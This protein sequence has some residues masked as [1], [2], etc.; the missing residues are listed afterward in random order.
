MPSLFV[1]LIVLVA[2][3]YPSYSHPPHHYNVLRSK[4]LR[5]TEP[6]RININKEKVFVASSIYDKQ[7]ELASGAW[8]QNLL[9]LV[10]L[11]GP[12]NV[13]LSVFEDDPDN[14]ARASLEQFSKQLKCNSSI[15][16]GHVDRAALPHVELPTGEKR[17]KR[18]EFLAHVRNRALAPLED[19]KSAAYSVHFDKLLYVNDVVFDPI[20]AANLIFSTNIDENG[21]AKYDA[22]CA[23]DFINPFKYYDTFATRDDQGNRIGVPI[24]PWF[25]G[26]D[27]S[28]SRRDVLDQKDAVR[29]RSCWG[30]MTVFNSA[31][32][33]TIPIRFRANSD[34][35]WDASECCLIHAD[36]EAAV[37]R[38]GSA[39]A[40]I[41]LNPYIRVAYSS[42]T[43]SYLHISRRFERLFAPLQKLLNTSLGL[44]AMNSRRTQEVGEQYQDMVWE[45]DDAAWNVSGNITSFHYIPHLVTTCGVAQ[46]SLIMAT[47]R[48][49][50][51]TNAAL[52]ATPRQTV[53]HQLRKKSGNV[54][55][56]QHLRTYANGFGRGGGYQYSRFQQAGGLMRRW[57]ARPTFYYEVGGLAGAC[58]GFYIYNL[59]VVPVSGRRRFNIVSASTEQQSGQELYQQVIQE[60]QGR[61]L[62][63]S[64][65][66]HKLVQRVLNRLIPHSGLPAETND[67]EV[68][69]I[70]DEQKNAFV[71]PGGKVFVFSGILDVCQG[72]AG[73]AAVLGHEIA[74]NVAHHSAERMSSY[75]VFLPVA[76]VASLLLGLGDIGNVFTRMVVDLAF[77]R[78]GSRKQESEADYIG[79]M[80]M[81]QACYDPS[82]AVGLWSRMHAAEHD[83]PPEFI[84][85]HP[86]SH[87]RMEKIQSWLGDAELKR[88]QSGCGQVSDYANKFRDTFSFRWS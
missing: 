52:R 35:Y 21:K 4:A 20:D 77:L 51:S 68:H 87:N 14:L 55:Q 29:V 23:A 76:I 74:H 34:I 36:L 1:L 83:A 47:G 25:S 78:P 50:F 62:P 6:G 15:V 54:W 73:L 3:I 16:A 17:L 80:M 56:K 44:P 75:A 38:S 37:Q 8:A 88:E 24:Y 81:A 30:G 27:E 69:V 31:S 84:S 59:E 85:T 39:S 9:D 7:G 33:T 40:D 28:N 48:I 43:F 10:D 61:I 12:E 53:F 32:C 13:F 79:L 60:Y 46:G 11:L 42:R 63:P 65:P 26:A 64:H 41:Y 22:A 72:E 57:A 49:F 66:Q 18:I 86:S 71:I 58:G 82:A 70:R 19:P 67:W 2:V 5:S 45:F